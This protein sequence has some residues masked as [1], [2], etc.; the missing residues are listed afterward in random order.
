MDWEKFRAETA[1]RILGVLLGPSWAVVDR[2]KAV[3]MAIEYADE[4]IEQLKK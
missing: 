3:K 2:K 1:A 4:L